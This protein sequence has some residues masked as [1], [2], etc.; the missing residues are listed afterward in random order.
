MDTGGSFD[1]VTAFDL[2]HAPE[3]PE[4]RDDGMEVKVSEECV[5]VGHVAF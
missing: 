4:K 3:M 5:R 1:G 2:R